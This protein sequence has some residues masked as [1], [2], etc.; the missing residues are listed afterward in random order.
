MYDLVV[1]N[2]YD[3]LKQKFSLKL[4]GKQGKTNF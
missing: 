1:L 4:K 3:K 2:F